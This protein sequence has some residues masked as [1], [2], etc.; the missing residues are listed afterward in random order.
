MLLDGGVGETAEGIVVG[1]DIEPVGQQVLDGVLDRLPAARGRNQIFKVLRFLER[2]YPDARTTDLR[3]SL[4][5][6][7]AQNKRRGMVVVIS[8]FYDIE[9][10]EDDLFWFVHMLP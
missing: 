9:G 6:F 7:V 8:D 10:F 5:T 4:D 3:A 2:D 1:S